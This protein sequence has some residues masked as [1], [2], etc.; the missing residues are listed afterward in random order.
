MLFW[1]EMLDRLTVRVKELS[2]A[3]INALHFEMDMISA[4]MFASSICGLF[5]W[6]WISFKGGGMN[7][8]YNNND[9]NDKYNH[10]NENVNPNLRII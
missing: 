7:N 9:D 8:N 10:N 1:F 6:T 4:N 3:E 2:K 5:S